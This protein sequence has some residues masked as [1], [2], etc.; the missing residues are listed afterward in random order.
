L[1][2]I[3]ESLRPGEQ[4]HVYYRD[5]INLEPFTT[6]EKDKEKGISKIPR[7]DNVE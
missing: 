7:E 6:R 1:T 5:E 4:F 2:E 3:F